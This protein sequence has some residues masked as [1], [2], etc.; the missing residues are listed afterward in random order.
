MS[1]NQL[2]LVSLQ[3]AGFEPRGRGATPLHLASCYGQ[4]EAVEMLVGTPGVNVNATTAEG[5]TALH[6]AAHLGHTGGEAGG[7]V[8]EVCKGE[9]A[10]METLVGTPGD[11]RGQHGW[12]L[13]S[14]C[15]GLKVRRGGKPQTQHVMGAVVVLEKALFL[16]YSSVSE[17]R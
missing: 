16:S 12:M 7:G 6:I 8:R 15:N 1:L 11:T 17:A 3:V 4:V 9:R 10:H 2:N 5:L 13:G 14:T